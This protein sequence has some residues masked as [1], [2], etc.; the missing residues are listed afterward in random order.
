MT[1][2]RP[3]IEFILTYLIVSFIFL[4][5]LPRHCFNAR[6]AILKREFY[7]S[8]ILYEIPNKINKIEE[9][10]FLSWTIYIVLCI[11]NMN[12]YCFD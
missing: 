12:I 4:L 3:H 7:L 2:G 5:S 11:K 6:Q 9:G 8:R 1:S 10:D